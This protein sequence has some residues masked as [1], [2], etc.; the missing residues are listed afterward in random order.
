VAP[1]TPEATAGDLAERAWRDVRAVLIGT[2]SYAGAA[3]AALRTRGCRDVQVYSPSGRAAAF[4][5]SHDARPVADLFAALAV[6]DLVVSCSGARGRGPSSPGLSDGAAPHPIGLLASATP[7]G[8]GSWRA[9]PPRESVPSPRPVRDPAG[10]PEL[11]GT[12][13]IRASGSERDPHGYVLDSAVLGAARGAAG[14]PLAIVDLA[15]HR[16]IDP[17]V[18]GAP[19][20][21]L[22][23]L[24]AL[25]ARQ[26]ADGMFDVSQARAMVDAAAREFEETRLGRGA[27]RAVVAL[28]DQ[29]ERQIA[30]EVDTL[31]AAARTAGPDV[32]DEDLT[33]ITHPVRRRVHAAL[34]P[35]IVAARAQAVAAAR[36]E[37][38]EVIDGAQAIADSA[39]SDCRAATAQ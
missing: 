7:H 31:A 26:S 10:A 27:D 25:G 33:S 20:V 19:G 2:G 30:A 37:A 21:V 12:A 8:S 24:A 38:A 6:A 11:R 5:A 22:Y 23:D 1:V 3:L 29:A 34:H 35:A 28:L 18:A 9:T 32:T 15:L 39:L 16:D 14:R 13:G 36:Q 4:A 17:L